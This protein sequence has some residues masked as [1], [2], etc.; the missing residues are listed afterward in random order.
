MS[1]QLIDGKAI[2]ARILDEVRQRVERLQSKGVTP[3]LAAVLVGDDPAS[4]TYVASKAKACE[5]LGIYS[6][7]I[8]KDASLSQTKLLSIVQELNDDPA[9][10]G[11]LV[12][13]PVPKAI[14]EL[15][16]TVAIRPEKDVDGFHPYNVGMMLIG[17][18]TMLP[19]TPF[20]IIKLLEYSNID[21]AGKEVV[22]VG[23]SNIVGKPV[24]ALLIQKGR[25]ADATVTIAHSRTKNLAE[26][27]R[28]AD[29]L[30]AAIGRPMTILADMV[31][32]GAAV[33]DVGVNRI[34]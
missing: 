28:R 26:V 10:H 11:I 18:P 8:R 20:G 33:I 3:G 1:A 21:P 25:W 23:R 4:A 17:R 7:V 14:D 22:V 13:S 19:C 30:I 16:V 24:A 12:Q 9:I 27:C 2:A 29:I 5:K 6:R 34:D 32:P 15:A 31:K